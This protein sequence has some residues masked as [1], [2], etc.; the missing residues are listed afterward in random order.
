MLP[1]QESLGLIFMKK[2]KIIQKFSYANVCIKYKNGKWKDDFKKIDI[3]SH[4]YN[5][6]YDIIRFWGR[7]IDFSDNL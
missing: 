3:K 2:I 5:Y 1:W 6:F 7:D 4:T